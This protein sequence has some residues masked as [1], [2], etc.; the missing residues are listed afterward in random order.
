MRRRKRRS[1]FDPY[2]AYVFSRWQEGCKNGSQLYREI[3]GK[4]YSGSEQMVHRFLRRLR[5]QLPL[6][7]TVEAP[8]TP[9]QDFVAKEAIWLLYATRLT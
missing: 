6:V 5:E 2:A 7:Q 9:V 3:K 4:G 1:I 8:P